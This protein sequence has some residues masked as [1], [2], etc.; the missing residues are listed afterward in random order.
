MSKLTE[1]STIIDLLDYIDSLEVDSDSDRGNCYDLDPVIN[2]M[3]LDNMCCSCPEDSYS[4]RKEDFK[5]AI[6]E[7]ITN[8]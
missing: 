2:K 5:L 8:D 6:L 7:L 1:N 3:K 4:V